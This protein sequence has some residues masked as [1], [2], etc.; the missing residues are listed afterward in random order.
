[1][2][3]EILLIV[4]VHGHKKDIQDG[5]MKNYLRPPPSFGGISPLTL[6]GVSHGHVDIDGWLVSLDGGILIVPP[7]GGSSQGHVVID[8]WLVSTD[9]GMLIIPPAG[10]TS[11]GHEVIG[12]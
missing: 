6:G 8:G 5:I 1:M 3:C 12:G 10:G 9:G 7:V 4:I 2:K 11:H